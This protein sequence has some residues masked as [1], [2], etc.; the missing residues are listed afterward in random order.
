MSSESGK[1]GINIIGH[2]SSSAGLGNTARLFAS[3]LQKNGHRIAGFNLDYG[4]SAEQHEAISFPIYR[5]VPDLPYSN[6]LIIP[7]INQL[8]SIWLRKAPEL[9]NPRFRNAGLIFWELPV[10]PKAW[11]SSLELFDVLLTSSRYVRT[12]LELALPDIPCIHAEHP[13]LVTNTSVTGSSIREELGINPADFVCF[14]NF[15]LRSD[16]ARKNPI[17]S[18]TAFL[19]AFPNS[20]DA[21]LLLK[22]SPI[23]DFNSSAISKTIRNVLLNDKRIMTI[24]KTMEYS[25]VQELYR[26]AD[27][28]IS[29]HRAEGLGLGPMEAMAQ[30]I[31]AICTGYSGNMEYMNPGNSYLVPY[32][33]RPPTG[34]SWQYT[35]AFAGKGAYWAEADITEAA[36]ILC[37][38]QKNNEDRA[39]KAWR[40]QRDI[41]ERQEYAWKAPYTE[42]MQ[43]YLK[44]SKRY[45][46]RR[47]LLRN[48]LLQEV[49]DPTL[50]RLG[51]KSAM[52]KTA[53]RL[54]K[55]VLKR[56]S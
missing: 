5:S 43:G 19:E 49:L 26:C 42:L 9:L 14:S 27:V 6:N 37:C 2:L 39:R 17:A 44:E 23:A 50:L 15:D 55:S 35:P 47:S 4:G 16:P 34:V 52:R 32:R 31:P 53:N 18:I 30:G 29:L 56:R 40:G 8:S 12:S 51:V 7:S 24:S 22:T 48:V 11:L 21:V 10:I 41:L 3:A 38:A 1:E 33:L 46:N 20:K 36:R 45:L 54:G 28:F 25:K 13:L